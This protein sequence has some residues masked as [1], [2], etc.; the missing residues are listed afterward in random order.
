MQLVPEGQLQTHLFLQFGGKVFYTKENF[1]GLCLLLQ[2]ND[3]LRHD[4]AGRADVL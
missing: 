4:G 3:I 2:N 1:D